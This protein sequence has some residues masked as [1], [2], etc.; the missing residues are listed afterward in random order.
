[1][2]ILEAATPIVAYPILSEEAGAS[3]MQS[4]GEA[5]EVFMNQ[6]GFEKHV[7]ITTP[8]DEA[9]MHDILE[10][11]V[12]SELIDIQDIIKNR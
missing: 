7:E 11:A 2:D 10:D 12:G 3:T 6:I 8:A 9:R 1:M 5:R 4:V